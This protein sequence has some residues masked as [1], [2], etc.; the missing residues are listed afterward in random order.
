MSPFTSFPF[1]LSL[2][3]PQVKNLEDENKKLDTK[4]GILK[5]QEEYEGKVDDIV[6][7]LENELEQQIESLL[8]DQ[9]NLQDELLKK[10]EEVENTK[11]RSAGHTQQ[12]L[13]LAEKCDA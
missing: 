6:K 4:L 9:E 8:R 12:V 1:R 3:L 13:I 7:Q 2:T 11:Q 5:E 10:H